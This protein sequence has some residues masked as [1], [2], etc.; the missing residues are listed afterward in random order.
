MAYLLLILL[1]CKFR[2][3]IKCFWTIISLLIISCTS[4]EDTVIKIDEG[5]IYLDDNNITIKA[6]ENAS[7]GDNYEINGVT[8]T[9][10]SGTAK[11]DD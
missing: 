5:P 6:R 2:Y 3:E 9:I 1:I 4:E 11:R 7:I 10:V 8:Y